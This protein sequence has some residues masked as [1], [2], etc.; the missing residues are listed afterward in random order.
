MEH[1]KA[2]FDRVEG[3]DIIFSS[4]LQLAVNQIAVLYFRQY[5]QKE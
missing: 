5:V 2:I 1:Y 4:F 3:F